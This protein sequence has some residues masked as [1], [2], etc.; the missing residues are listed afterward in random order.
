MARDCFTPRP[1]SVRP[2]RPFGSAEEAWM[3]F[4]RCQLAREEGARYTADAGEARPCDPDDVYR[5]AAALHRRRTLS[6]G[7]IRVLAGYGRRLAPPDPRL[8]EEEREA[9]LWDEALDRLETPLRA[10]GIVAPPE[11]S[12]PGLEDAR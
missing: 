2:S 8:D 5:A 11:M 7:H 9:R 12:L 1:L 6:A 4:W 3:W 10:K